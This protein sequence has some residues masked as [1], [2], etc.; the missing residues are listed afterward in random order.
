MAN[1]VRRQNAAVRKEE[2]L[3]T[4]V[5]EIA[6]RGFAST[7]VADVAAV[8]GISPALVFYHFASKDRL[9]AAAF[10]YAAERDLWRLT[11]AR[12]AGG[13]ALERLRAVLRLYSPTGSSSPSWTL[14]IDA[15]G[16]A[17]REPELRA[18]S[19]RLDLF[20][21]ESV[22]GV[23][24]DGVE[25]GEFHCPDPHAAAWRITALLDGLAIQVTVHPGVLSR[26]E[27]DSWVRRQ[28]ESEL[29]LTDGAL[30]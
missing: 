7:R 23:I 18:V 10:E 3:R 14:W 11:K 13:S 15:W 26:K 6:R 16:A 22:A 4:A 5:E 12:E 28:A 1:R 19:R 8:L 25:S 30:A 27:M 9:L 2:I 21:K 20:W 17:L 29:G 24:V